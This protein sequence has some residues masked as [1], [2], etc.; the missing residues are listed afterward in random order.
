[1][2]VVAVAAAAIVDD[3]VVVVTVA[4]ATAAVVDV[5]VVVAVAVATVVVVA[6]AVA[7]FLGFRKI[8]DENLPLDWVLPVAKKRPT[9]I[10]FPMHQVTKAAVTRPFCSQ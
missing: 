4:V 2:V 6:V 7:S 10:F 5:V 3:G 9:Q 1:M 8:W